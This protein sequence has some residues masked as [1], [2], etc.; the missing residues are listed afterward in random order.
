ML[1]ARK[2]LNTAAEA[3]KLPHQ[4]AI[5]VSRPKALTEHRQVSL[6]LKRPATVLQQ[7]PPEVK[8]HNTVVTTGQPF[9]TNPRQPPVVTTSRSQSQPLPLISGLNPVPDSAIIRSPSE[10]QQ[11]AAVQTSE[12]RVSAFRLS[13]PQ[14]SAFQP[15]SPT[16]AAD[17]G[18]RQQPTRPLPRIAQ[19][20][21]ILL[22]QPQASNT[23]TLYDLLLKS[24]C[25]CS[26]AASEAAEKNQR[27]PVLVNRWIAC[28][29]LV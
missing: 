9:L 26:G 4:V 6:E 14:R 20:G 18:A 8:R 19:A 10:P 28:K 24:E 5:H 27:L 29:M 12:P 21:N 16:K 17:G 11:I 3:P 23:S 15:L 25:K 22:T 13:E 1:T 2:E 7:P